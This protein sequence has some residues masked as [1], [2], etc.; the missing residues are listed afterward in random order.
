MNVIKNLNIYTGKKSEFD[1]QNSTFIRGK[2]LNF[3]S[4]HLNFAKFQ[5]KNLNDSDKI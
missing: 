3:E 2:I 4:G 5:E 1:Y